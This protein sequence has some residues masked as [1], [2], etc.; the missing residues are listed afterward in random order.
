[1]GI[2]IETLALA[3]K[4]AKQVAKEEGVNQDFL[5]D[6]VTDKT[7]AEFCASI[8]SCSAVKQGNSFMGAVTLTD[9]QSVGWMSFTVSSADLFLPLS[10]YQQQKLLTVGM[11]STGKPLVVGKLL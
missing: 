11:A 5:S 6:F 3:R 1:M 9:M 2:S 7:T 10:L 8:T 4:Y